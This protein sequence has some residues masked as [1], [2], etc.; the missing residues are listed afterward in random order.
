MFPRTL[1][2]VLP[3]VSRHFPVVL[4]TGPRQVGKSTLLASCAS[5]DRQ[6]TSLDDLNLRALACS[7][8]ALFVQQYPAPVSIDEVQYA[9]HL[10]SSLKIQVDQS[11]KKG[12]YWLTGSQKFVLM[13][14]V[15][16]SLAGRVAVLDMLG[17][18]QAERYGLG[19]QRHP[20]LPTSEW[21]VHAKKHRCLG[22]GLRE[23]Y[24]DIW[25]GSFPEVLGVAPSMR[26]L[27]YRSYVQTY[28]QRD[29]ADLV[30]SLDQNMFYRF[31]VAVAAR[32][33]QVL[34]YADLSRDVG[35]SNKKAKEWMGV[36]EA[37][38]LV[39]LLQPYHNNHS[40]RMV[41]SPKIY[42][43]DTGLCSYLTQ[44]PT[45]ESMLSGAMS[46]ALL[47][48]YLFAEIVKSYWHQGKEFPGYYYRDH[49]QN[50]IDLVLDSGDAFYPVEFKKTATPSRSSFKHFH[51]LDKLG[52]KRGHGVVLCFVD[53][54]VPLSKDVTAVPINFL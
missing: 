26:D 34:N 42:F 1:E 17:L 35:V 8:P 15:T 37:S 45:P 25:Y 53:D 50:E 44:W 48:T 2:L 46:V 24:R 30:Q 31:V 32:T 11:K 39:F 18:S 3:E 33:A 21:M 51:C 41:K 22:L 19:H 7:D 6:H 54:A 20:F 49:D 27:F 28:L 14:G 13:R 4:I 9:P 43:L 36:L 29:V 10:F 12:M 52:K 23:I 47:E 38:G 5:A 16:E 40:K